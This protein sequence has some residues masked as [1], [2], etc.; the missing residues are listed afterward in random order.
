APIAIGHS[1][2]F[3]HLTIANEIWLSGLIIQADQQTTTTRSYMTID[4][5]VHNGVGTATLNRPESMNAI[6][7][8]ILTE[9][10]AGIRELADNPEVKAIVLTGAGKA[11]SAGLDLKNRF[12]GGEDTPWSKETN[13]ANRASK[14]L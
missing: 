10:T 12:D 11:F 8:E 6:T 9:W 4:L 2:S 14:A 5:H 3:S 1:F 13:P 7:A